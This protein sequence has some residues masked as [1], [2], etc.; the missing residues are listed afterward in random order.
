MPTSSARPSVH[1]VGGDGRRLQ[2][3]DVLVTIDLRHGGKA[4][5]QNPV[6]LRLR[7]QQFLRFGDKLLGHVGCSP[8]R[9]IVGQGAQRRHAGLLRIGIGDV[10]AQMCAAK[11][12][13]K[14]MFLDRLDENFNRWFIAGNTDSHLTESGRPAGRF[15]RWGFVRRGGP[16]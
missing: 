8:A 16:Q 2:T 7:G 13:D 15:P 4:A 6:G 5:H 12:D 11:N 9:L 3:V 10:V 14:S 1:G